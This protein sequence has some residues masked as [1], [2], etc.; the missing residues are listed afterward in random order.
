MSKRG[1][2]TFR[3][4]QLKQTKSPSAPIVE[5]LGRNVGCEARSELEWSQ[6][7]RLDFL[8][9][10]VC[11]E[12]ASCQVENEARQPPVCGTPIQLHPIRHE[13]EKR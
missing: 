10:V 4:L 2:T 6:L 12:L 3:T 11:E 13:A 8:P 5:T 9:L 1:N 7:I